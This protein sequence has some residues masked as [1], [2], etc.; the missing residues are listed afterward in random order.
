MAQALDAL[1]RTLFQ[2]ATAI[3]L[4][5]ANAQLLAFSE[6]TEAWYALLDYAPCT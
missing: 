4:A 1:L 2:P 6:S 3:A 5:A